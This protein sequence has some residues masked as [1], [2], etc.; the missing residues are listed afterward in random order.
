MYE[1]ACGIG[2]NLYSNLEILQEDSGITNI[3]IYGNEYIKESVDDGNLMLDALLEAQELDG[4]P[5][6]HKG[7]IC[8]GDSTDLEHV[9]A[10]A[11]D[12]V[13]T[14]YIR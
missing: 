11:F 7:M 9:P 3:T 5:P 4:A 8:H 1:S 6:N 2:L 12:I 13:F 10:N 14:G